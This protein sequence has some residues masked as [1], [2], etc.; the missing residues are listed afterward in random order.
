MTNGTAGNPPA[1]PAAPAPAAAPKTSGL[2]IAGLILAFIPIFCVNFIGVILGIVA[3]VQIGKRPQELKGQGLAIAAIIIGVLWFFVGILAAIAIPNF[4]KFQSRAK[5]SEAKMNL[6]AIYNAEQSSYAEN[7]SFATTFEAMG[8]VQYDEA[9]YTYYIGSDVIESTKQPPEALPPGVESYVNAEGF[10]AVAVGN[11][12][13][14]PTLDV[15]VIDHENRLEN[16]INDI[17][18]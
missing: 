15:W 13:G 16:V 10:R 5:Q 9:R 6:K 12:D 2:A 1:A 11:I 17:V 7:G 4:I 14:D 8:W 18:E 3:L